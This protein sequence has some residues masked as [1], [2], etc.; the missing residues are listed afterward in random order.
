MSKSSPSTKPSG[1]TVPVPIAIG[2]AAALVV[3]VVALLIVNRGDE[4]TSPPAF[5]TTD[6]TSATSP[7]TNIIRSQLF[8]TMCATIGNEEPS[9]QLA[10][11]LELNYYFSTPVGLC[12]A[13]DRVMGEQGWNS[14]RVLSVALF[15]WGT[16]FINGAA[17]APSEAFEFAGFDEGDYD[18]D[19]QLSGGVDVTEIT[20]GGRFDPDDSDDTTDTTMG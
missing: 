19:Y 3:A 2:L 20:C 5:T 17:G 9:A 8:E 6:T 7:L 1:I 12:V 13:S 16:V 18:C 15:E 10:S 11:D 4:G 14:D